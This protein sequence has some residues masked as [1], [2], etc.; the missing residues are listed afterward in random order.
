MSC[1]LEKYSRASQAW[2]LWHQVSSEVW[3]L[4]VLR[5][6]DWSD[7]DTPGNWIGCCCIQTD[8]IN[9]SFYDTICVS[10]WA[11]WPPLTKLSKPLMN[12]VPLT[13]FILHQ[14]SKMTLTHNRQV[15]KRQE[16]VSTNVQSYTMTNTLSVFPG[17]RRCCVK[18]QLHTSHSHQIQILVCAWL[19]SSIFISS[20]MGSRQLELIV[21]AH[22]QKLN[23][24]F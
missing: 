1:Y 20:F 9:L 11:G 14:A 22:F 6:S 10:R 13:F 4:I 21:S 24:D 23:G 19:S 7:A 5:A 17:L 3:H 12:H 2:L 18:C 16:T 15:D 8:L